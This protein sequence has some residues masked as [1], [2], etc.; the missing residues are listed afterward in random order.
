MYLEFREAVETAV[1][2][3]NDVLDEGLPLHP[4]EEQTKSVRDWRQIGLGVMGIADML[5]KMGIEY[6]DDIS[7][8]TCDEIAKTLAET[9][10]IT[11]SRL[12]AKYGAYPKFNAEHVGDSGYFQMHTSESNREYILAAGLRNS[13]LLTIAPTGSISTMLGISGG[14]EPIYNTHYTRTTK[15]LHGHDETYTIYTPI[16]ERFMRENG[17]TDVDS[18]PKYFVTAMTLNGIKR[19]KMQSVWQQHIDAS[20]S[21]T[22]NLPNSATI[23]DVVKLYTEAWS[24]GLKGLTIFRDGCERAAILNNV[25]KDEKKE[26]EEVA[27]TVEP[28]VSFEEFANTQLNSITPLSRADLGGRLSG[29]TYVKDIA[30]GKLYITINRDENDNL[31]EVFIDPGKSGGCSAN[32]ECIGRYASACMRGGM[33]ILDIIDVTRGVKCSACTQA[34]G[35]KKKIDGL[36]CGDVIARTIKDEYDRYSKDVK[37]A[38]V[39]KKSKPKVETVVKPQQPMTVPCPECGEEMAMGGGC[40]ICL[41]C[42]HSK[43]D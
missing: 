7:L 21:S 39:V 33:K 9:A 19:I 10:I 36:S 23:D 41:N 18:L 38:K 16:V 28:E 43:C 11:S 29:S 14:I 25:S 31:V 40:N 15:S 2:A 12:A 30:C 42:G 1:I 27:V 20:I 34:K 37:P 24:Y 4:L 3:L 8:Y 17:I 6:G 5:I 13:Q 26:E 32:A 22:V 35:A